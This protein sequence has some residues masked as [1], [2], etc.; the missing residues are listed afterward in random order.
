MDAFDSKVAPSSIPTA[1]RIYFALHSC[2]AHYTNTHVYTLQATTVAEFLGGTADFRTDLH[3][4]CATLMTHGESIDLFV[5]LGVKM[6]PVHLK[7]TRTLAR[8]HTLLHICLNKHESTHSTLTRLGAQDAECRDALQRFY[9]ECLRSEHD[10][11]IEVPRGCCRSRVGAVLP[12][13]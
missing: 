3:S 9:A 7:D 5:D 11:R 6:T 13:R 2:L 10:R 12:H 1:F 8:T 4:T